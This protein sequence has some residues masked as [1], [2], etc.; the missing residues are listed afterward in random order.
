MGI[1]ETKVK[2]EHLVSTMGQC[3]SLNW[4]RAT[5]IDNSR[6]TARIIL[7]WDP[8][9]LSVTVLSDSSQ[10]IFGKAEGIAC[11]RSFYLS[12]IYGSNNERRQLWSELRSF[13][14]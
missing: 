3:F 2:R 12:V 13:K 8:G 1:V 7:G 10:M 6:S 5:N 14:S 4:L 9:V 11:H